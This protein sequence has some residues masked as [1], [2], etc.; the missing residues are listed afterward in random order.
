MRAKSDLVSVVDAAL[1]KAIAANRSWRV[2]D[3]LGWTRVG[4][5]E[6]SGGYGGDLGD[7]LAVMEGAGRRA[8]DIPLLESLLANT[9][10]GWAGLLNDDDR[11]ACVLFG[12][13]D[14]RAAG[15]KGE[16][17]MRLTGALAGVSVP[18]T[19]MRCV[20]VGTIDEPNGVY[21]FDDLS[22][23][24]RVPAHGSDPAAHRCTVHFDAA[25][26]DEANVA[27]LTRS[28]LDVTAHW[29]LFRAA[30][31]LGT[32][33]RVIELTTEHVRVRKQFGRPL[34]GFQAVQHHVA[35]MVCERDLLRASVS[36]ART[37]HAATEP[38]YA[39]RLTAAQASEVVSTSA[40]QLFGAMGITQEHQLHV[41]TTSLR[42]L[43]D[44]LHAHRWWREALGARLADLDEQGIWTV[45]TTGG[46]P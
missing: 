30:W 7:A 18:A 33:E 44:D 12:G 22:D 45:I 8:V 24:E 40:H 19:A 26:V 1:A 2:A 46:K 23:V 31:I 29:A 6:D 14:I 35:R 34:A 43:R 36:L 10:L 25:R 3:E 13:S 21:L 4:I 16:Q 27:V 28:A 9:I 39:A 15:H 37:R 20:L 11:P 42:R 41:F 17:G 32:V 38:A 5:A